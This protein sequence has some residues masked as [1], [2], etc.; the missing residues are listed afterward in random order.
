MFRALQKQCGDVTLLGPAPFRQ[1][2]EKVFN[3][4]ARTLLGKRYDYSHSLSYAR[5]CARYFEKKLEG[6]AYDVIFAPAAATGLAY[7]H[8][9]VPIVYVSDVT[10]ALLRNYYPEFTDLLQVSSREGD[11]IEQAAIDGSRIALYSSQWAADSAVREYGAE[12]AKV[13]VIPFGANL[14]SAPRKEDLRRRAKTGRITLLFLAVNWQR[15]GGDVAYETLLSLTA[16]GIDAE[17]IV[18]GVAPPDGISHG[19]MTVIPFLSKD[20]P[21]QLQ[22]LTELFLT[23]D[24]L[25]LPT[26]YDCTPI[27]ICEA[28]AFGIP[29]VTTDTGGVSSLVV[30]GE[31]GILLPPAARGDQYADAICALYRDDEHYAALHESSRAAYDTRLNWDS[32]AHSVGELF[33]EI[34]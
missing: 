18:C 28:N 14:D 23:T 19:N 26:R 34:A 1:L 7:L 30:N 21:V 13:R 5:R 27:V 3:R 31:N 10:F 11:I 24:F 16:R 29:V 32:W 2:G 17:L 20:D 33:A 22:A 6:Q 15:K 9:S 4:L 12:P 25:L 8:T